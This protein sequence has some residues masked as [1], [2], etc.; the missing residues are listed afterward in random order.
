MRG[1]VTA[2]QH[3]M[4]MRTGARPVVPVGLLLLLFPAA[5]LAQER[6]ERTAV[7]LE[8]NTADEDAEIR[9]EVTGGDEGLAT[10]SVTAPDGRVVVDFRAPDSRLGIRHVTLESPEPKDD[11]RL[12]ADFPSG[13]YRFAGTT[14]GGTRLEGAATLSHAF[15]ATTS[16]VH[17][18]AGQRDVPVADMRISWSPVADAAAYV[19]VIEQELTAQEIRVQL[20]GTATAFAIPDGFLAA[21]TAYKLSIG[22]VSRE[23]NRSFVETDFRTTGAD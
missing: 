10:L 11:G 6:F 18:R 13:V 23:G 9:F 22:S 21:G 15:P 1:R 20:P 3:G 14:V 12:R 2:R 17:P 8:R 4:V 5:V 19:V 7:Y 16:F